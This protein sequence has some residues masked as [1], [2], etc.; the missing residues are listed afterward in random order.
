MSEHLEQ[1]RADRQRPGPG[2]LSASYLDN[3]RAKLAAFESDGYDL[4]SA[5]TDAIVAWADTRRPLK[6]QELTPGGRNRI[7]DAFGNFYSWA[8]EKGIRSDNPTP[9]HA[10]DPRGPLGVVT[11][12]QVDAA[13][14]VA[15]EPRSRSWFAL[16]AFEGF[17]AI[18]IAHLQAEDLQLGTEPPTRRA[19]ERDATPDDHV[20]LH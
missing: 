6:G 17:K 13:F 10:D 11:T 12:A 14:R 18:E 2:H 19:R 5:T 4:L 20:P 7:Y 3:C 15:T 16:M 1:W 8:N 9:E